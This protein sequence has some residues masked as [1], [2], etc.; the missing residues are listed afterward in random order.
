[1]EAEKLDSSEWQRLKYSLLRRVNSETE[2]LRLCITTVFVLGLIAH[3]FGLV[4]LLLNHDCLSEFYLHVT[5]PWKI[6]LGRFM[7]P[8]LRYLM[9]E[10]IVLPW[11][12]G[13]TGLL[14]LALSAHLISKMFRLDRIWEN[15]L[16]GGILTTNVTV[17][18]LIATY[19]HDF[20]G[21]MLAL[22]LTVT[23]AY[24][25]TKMREGFSWKYTILGAA[26][27]TASFGLYQAYLA[28]T[29]TLMCMDAVLQTL[30]GCRAKDSIRHLLRALPMGVIAVFVYAIG[31]WLTL[32]LSGERL[33]G[34]PGNNMMLIGEN[35][36]RW[37]ELIARS[38]TQVSQDLYCAKWDGVKGVHYDASLFVARLNSL[39][40]LGVLWRLGVIV[41]KKAMKWPEILLTLA[42]LALLPLCMLCVSVVSTEF[43]QLMRFALYLFYPFSLAI[44]ALD[45]TPKNWK[46]V[47]PMAL[48]AI[49]ILNNIQISNT[50]YEKKELEQQATLSTMTRVLSRLEQYEDYQYNESEVAIIREINKNEMNS[51]INTVDGIIGVNYSS[52]ITYYATIENYFNI[53]LQTPIKICEV[54]KLLEIMQTEAFQ[55]MPQFPE[56]GSI[57]TIDGVVVVKLAEESLYF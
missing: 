36:L 49:V 57:A 46:Q 26:C 41:K 34:G 48:I 53:I 22:L 18:A 47:L 52:P 54:N 7:E 39:L 37:Q 35:L 32:K 2:R 29:L 17:T 12:T 33:S 55:K 28:V 16:L 51:E 21:D 30:R 3:G 27:L 40:S 23:A 6:A 24:L 10:I 45:D 56:K 11:L 44:L 25:W 31:V 38:Y 15:I 14:C 1:M 5:K 43:H 20:A 4:N 50:V 19:V 9:G 42:L 8:I 13:L